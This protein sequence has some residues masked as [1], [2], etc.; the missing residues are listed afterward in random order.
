MEIRDQQ[1]G[2]LKDQKRSG[3]LFFTSSHYRP[4]AWSFAW[5]PDKGM[6]K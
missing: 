2:G 3:D 5:M 1:K 4:F 6:R